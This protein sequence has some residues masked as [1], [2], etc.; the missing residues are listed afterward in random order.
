M[1][2]SVDTPSSQGV[3]E[4]TRLLYSKSEAAALLSISPR[5]LD[6]MIALKR[7]TARRVGARVLIPW[8]AMLKFCKADHSTRRVQ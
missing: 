1:N 5:T 8:E 7:I 3:P 4:I 6:N 2:L